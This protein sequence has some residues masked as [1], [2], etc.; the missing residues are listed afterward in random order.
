M[1]ANFVCP[2]ITMELYETN[3]YKL[4]KFI[5]SER[6]EEELAEEYLI[7]YDFAD[8]CR[9]SKCIQS[10][11]IRYLLPFYFK[12]IEQAVIYKN[13]IALDVY[14]QFNSM[15]FYNQKI[16]EHAVGEK[17]YQHIMEFYINMT[18]KS[19]EMESPGILAWISL[20]N[21][22]VALY[23]NSILKLLKKIFE[24]SLKIKYSFFRYLSVLLFKESDNLLAVNETRAFWTSDIWDYDSQFSYD[25]FWNT[26]IVE[27]FDKKI[28]REKIVDLYNDVKPLLC[29]ILEPELMDLFYEQMELSFAT[30]V[31]QQRK[32]EYLQKIN[33]KSEKHKY[34][35]SY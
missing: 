35:D 17:T 26:N 27:Y 25:F 3:I 19:M 24:G 33:Y 34:W 16:F 32:F 28:D 7:L 15:M 22:T 2:P 23:A 5:T 18:I 30:G 10:E 21:T 6:I 4:Q 8:D 20:F 1:S 29:S 13:K 31:F 11:L 9:Y 14:C 12:T